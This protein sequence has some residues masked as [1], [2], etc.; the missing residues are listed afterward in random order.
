MPR[1]GLR[2]R[3]AAGKINGLGERV[4]QRRRDLGLTQMQLCARLEIATGSEW[5]VDRQDIL[6]IEG[7]QRLVGDLEIVVLA[8]V[9]EM[10]ASELLL[11]ET[12]D[13]V[14]RW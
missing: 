1:G 6:R 2:L 10:L 4:R 14:V 8:R 9:L 13:K 5:L 12:E 3:N 7:G 11:G